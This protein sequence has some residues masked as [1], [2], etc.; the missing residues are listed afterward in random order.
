[1]THIEH[2]ETSAPLAHHPIH[3]AGRARQ[4]TPRRGRRRRGQRRGRPTRAAQEG[5]HVPI[6]YPVLC[7]HKGEAT[8]AAGLA[9][10]GTPIS[11]L[12]GEA[13]TAWR[14]VA[15]LGCQI[16]VSLGDG[17]VVNHSAKRAGPRPRLVKL[18]LACMTKY[19]K[20]VNTIY[21]FR[22]RGHDA[23]LR[24]ARRSDQPD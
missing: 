14:L 7:T 12:V 18:V 11:P 5:A 9:P 15:S 17:R 2:G 24:S 16:C 4:K 21:R 23:V 10:V 6:L 3:S 13:G 22:H 8:A 1:M 19:G 20:F